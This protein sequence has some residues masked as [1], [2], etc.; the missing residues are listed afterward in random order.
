MNNIKSWIP[1]LIK[2]EIKTNLVHTHYYARWM[3]Y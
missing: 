1:I 2:I 3:Q